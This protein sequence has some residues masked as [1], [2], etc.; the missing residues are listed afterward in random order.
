MAG[1]KGFLGGSMKFGVADDASSP[2][3]RA[4]LLPLRLLVIAD[5]VPRDP[6]NAGASAP[7]A[8]LRVDASRFDDLFQKLRP[9]I[10]IDVPSV[11]AEGRNARVDL[12]PTSL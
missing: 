4:T 6:Y 9:R 3:E 5:L 11:L 7:A 1:D 10:A 12:A 8:P 2:D